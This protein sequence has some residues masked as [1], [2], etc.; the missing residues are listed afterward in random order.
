MFD[1]NKSRT[2]GYDLPMGISSNTTDGKNNTNSNA[3]INEYKGNLFEYLVAISTAKRLGIEAAFLQSFG[4]EA[5]QRL[6]FYQHELMELDRSLYTQLPVFAEEVAELLYKKASDRKIE[7]I[8]VMGKSAGASHDESYGECDI[9]MVSQK[10]QYPYSLKFCKYGAY[11]NTKSGGIRSFFNKY[12]A[13]YG[14]K[15]NLF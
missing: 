4:G 7:N 13:D 2:F 6:T 1:L 8:L 15:A 11:V 14:N 10:H 5:K 9:M 12:F 3:L